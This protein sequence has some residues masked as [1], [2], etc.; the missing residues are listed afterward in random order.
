[1]FCSVQTA[2]ISE[3]SVKYEPIYAIFAFIWFRDKKTLVS[4]FL[5]VIWEIGFLGPGGRRRGGRDLEREKTG[6]GEEEE[7]GIGK[8]SANI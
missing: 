8:K 2:E 3:T 7:E 4:R 5:C 6:A 1:M